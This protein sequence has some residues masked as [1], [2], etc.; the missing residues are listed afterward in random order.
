MIFASFIAKGAALFKCGVLHVDESV[1]LEK[2]VR[3]YARRIVTTVA[4]KLSW[5]VSMC[6]EPHDV[7]CLLLYAVLHAEGPVFGSSS[8]SSPQPAVVRFAAL[9]LSPEAF[10]PIEVHTLYFI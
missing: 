6:E 5:P 8:P 4:D 9:Y 1:A 7:S 3:I 2:M 10:N